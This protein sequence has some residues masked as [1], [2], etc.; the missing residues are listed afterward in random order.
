M[1]IQQGVKS[2]LNTNNISNSFAYSSANGIALSNTE[3]AIENT[4]QC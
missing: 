2:K 1:H 4:Y 3:N